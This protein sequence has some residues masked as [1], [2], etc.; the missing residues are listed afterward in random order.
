MSAAVALTI[1]AA[2]RS[3]ALVVATLAA[4]TLASL[5]VVSRRRVFQAFSFSRTPSKRTVAWGGRLDVTMSLENAKLLPLIWMRIQDEWPAGLVPH[6]F[7]LRPFALRRCQSLSLTVSLRWYERLRRHYS[8]DCL[9]RG[10]HYFGPVEIEAGDPF[11]IAG[12]VRVIPEREEIVVLPRVLEVPAFDALFGHPLVDAP[13]ARSFA[14]DP[15]ALRCTRPY[16]QGDRLSA[17]NWRATARTG[18]LHTNE[19]EP[20]TLAAVRILFDVNV[21]EHAW[22]GVDPGRVELLCV[23]AASLASACSA[24]GSSVGLASNA[25]LTGD[26]RPIDIEPQEGALAE[27][28]EALGR[29]FA[30][31][32]DDF[33]AILSAE[34]ATGRPDADCLLV[35]PAL[36]TRARAA[37]VELRSERSCTVVYVGRPAPEERG[38]VDVVLPGDFDWKGSDALRF[39]A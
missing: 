26:W 9:Q 11:G 32:A 33:S 16:Q 7:R 10:V 12:V 13:A 31:P 30:Y 25:R 8:V 35:V 18:K 1:A 37:L 21:L 34:L 39:S 4:A 28:L 14:T 3:D 5:A 22:M 38:S 15:T 29:V 20:T 19:F 24:E 6:G 2:V 23:A 27:V 36:R 17:V